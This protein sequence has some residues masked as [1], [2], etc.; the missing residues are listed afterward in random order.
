MSNA[1]H[2]KNTCAGYV[3]KDVLFDINMQIPA[4]K[5]TVIVGPNGCGKSTLLKTLCGLVPVRRGDI[6]IGDRSIHDFTPQMLARQIAFLPQNRPVC[7]ATAGQMVLHG[8]FPYLSYPR[9]Y[10]TSDQKIA[11]QAMERMGIS[12]LADAP[13]H[14][15]SG[16]MRQK[17][18]IAMALTQDTPVILF[19]EP[20][21][22]LDISHQLQMMEHARFLCREGKTV[23]MVLHDLPMA[24]KLADQLAVMQDG[25][26]VSCGSPEE[27]F[28]SGCLD[29]VF[30]V[31]VRRVQTADGWQYYSRPAQ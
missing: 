14:T 10:R 22:Y 3:S 30:R 6:L 28:D 13:I 2:I 12:G 19:D 29:A 11:Q 26:I 7:A 9:R 18:Y 16:G 8:R 20:T 1:V 31:S 15:L 5:I 21:T 4:G 23:V 27:I 24:L 25:K 17:V